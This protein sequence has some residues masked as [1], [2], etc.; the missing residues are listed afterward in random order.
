MGFPVNSIKEMEDGLRH[1]RQKMVIVILAN[2]NS[3]SDAVEFIHNN[4]HVMDI[5]SNDVDFY[6]PGYGINKYNRELNCMDIEYANQHAQEMFPDFHCDIQQ[7]GF[8]ERL[9]GR[10]R[11][12]HLSHCKI[13]DSPR[14]GKIF[15]NIAEFTDFVYEFTNRIDGY[16]YLGGCQMVLLQPNEEGLP[17]YSNASVYDLDAIIASRC[18]CSLDAFLHR[19]FN[20]I[21]EF[22][23]EHDNAYRGHS[24]FLNVLFRKKHKENKT[25]KI[26]NEVDKLYF[27]A[28][29]ED[30]PNDRYEIIIHDLIADM[31]RCL[32]WD[33][34]YEEFYFI[35]YSS[36]NIMKANSLKILLEH[37]G[38]HVWIAP[39]GIPQ[40]R[41]YPV[42]IPTALKL[43]KVFVLLLT[44]E[45]AR[46]QWVRREL[47][48][49]IGNS[50]NTKVKVLLSE[51]MTISDIRA[52]NELEFLLDRVQVKFDYSDVVHSQEMLDIFINE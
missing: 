34:A 17:D 4:F 42:V 44:P 47:A 13:I 6:L 2:A 16:H 33:V 29:R 8:F 3:D 5:I 37:H 25:R 36:Q 27:D 28:T 48:I 14:L 24:R 15:F 10:H 35:S 41:E 40:G 45:S 1:R 38:L 30:N 52:D 7:R 11:S 23:N 26:I 43:A 9:I 12:E 20:I 46:S 31:S 21:R 51:G 49:A 32:D 19:T 50:A 22:D 18:G 39:D